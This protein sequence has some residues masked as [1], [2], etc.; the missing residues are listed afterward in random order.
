MLTQLNTATSAHIPSFE[1]SI[2]WYSFVQSLVRVA[3]FS[4]FV[5]ALVANKVINKPVVGIH[6][7]S[8]RSVY[9]LVVALIFACFVYTYMFIARFDRYKM[10]PSMTQ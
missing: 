5:P 9:F 7:L 2:C 4:L 8:L 3:I 6:S 10:E 1:L